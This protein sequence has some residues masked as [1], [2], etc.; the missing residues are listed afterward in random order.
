MC[1]HAMCTFGLLNPCVLI[2]WCF[3]FA[4]P[5]QPGVIAP[6]GSPQPQPS[7]SVG[8]PPAQPKQV[9]VK[10]EPMAA[11]SPRERPSPSSHPQPAM[12]QSAGHPASMSTPPG[13]P[14][15]LPPGHPASSVHAQQLPPPRRSAPA[16]MRPPSP[17]LPP[18]AAAPP[19]EVCL[20]WNSYH[21]NMQATFPSLLNNEQF[22]DVTLACEGHSIKCHK[23]SPGEPRCVRPA[24]GRP[25]NRLLIASCLPDFNF[26]QCTCWL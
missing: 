17:V 23:V 13:H 26:N 3:P 9:D 8:R 15:G 16:P 10:R 20:R 4:V 6:D 1:V 7:A 11:A 19:P 2:L 25:A 21:S 22:V 18:Q 14:A 12:P 24:S 5:P